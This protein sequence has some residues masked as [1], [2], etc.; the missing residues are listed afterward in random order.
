M[1]K[2]TRLDDN[3]AIFITVVLGVVSIPFTFM[4]ILNLI[5]NWNPVGIVFLLPFLMVVVILYTMWLLLGHGSEKLRTFYSIVGL[6]LGTTIAILVLIDLSPCSGLIGCM[7]Q[8][9]RGLFVW[10]I[11]LTVAFLIS[12]YFLIQIR[13]SNRSKKARLK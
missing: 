1:K 7:S 11:G 12:L 13:L 2:G 8:G 3:I 6:V 5:D 9:F 10:G 4:A